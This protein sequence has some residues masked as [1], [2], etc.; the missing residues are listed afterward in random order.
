MS[1][2]AHAQLAHAEECVRLANF[3]R[4]CMVQRRLLE[5]RQEYLATARQ[6]D[7]IERPNGLPGPNPGVGTKR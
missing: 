1:Q 6:L 4:D 2:D 7:R 5:L 3:A